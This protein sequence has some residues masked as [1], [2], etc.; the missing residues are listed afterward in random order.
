MQPQNMGMPYNSPYNDYLLAIDELNGVGWWATDRN[1]PAGYVTIYVFV[2]NELRRNCDPATD[3]VVAF[4][5]L[6]DISATQEGKDFSELR[7]II[8]EIAPE[9]VEL[10]QPDFHFTVSPGVEYTHL[11]DFRDADARSA[12][13][14]YLRQADALATAEKSLADAR[15]AYASGSMTKERVAAM[16]QNVSK[17]RSQTEQA[18]S[19]VYKALRRSR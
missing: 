18:R 2:P 17:L 7:S 11:E 9:P 19:A 5:R 15:R 16:E 13:T 12:M 14:V 10:R 3:D 1:A 4:A 6:S 8:A